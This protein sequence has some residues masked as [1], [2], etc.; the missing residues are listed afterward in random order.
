MMNQRLIVATSNQDGH[1]IES[2]SCI[3]FK[4]MGENYFDALY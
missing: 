2:K 1:T 3:D 4:P